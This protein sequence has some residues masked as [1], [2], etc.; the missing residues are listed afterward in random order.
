[1]RPLLATL[2]LLACACGS[3]V[4]EPFDASP[5]EEDAGAQDGDSGVAD[6]PDSG[7]SPGR[8]ASAPRP[9]AATIRPD[10]GPFPVD[11]GKPAGLDASAI[12]PPDA[13]APRPDA[14]A[15]GPDAAAPGPDAGPSCGEYWAASQFTC[16][17]DGNSRVRCFSNELTTEPCP[18]G[19]LRKSSGDDLCL[20][21]S[22]GW[23]CSGSWGTTPSQSGDYFITAFGCWTD[24]IGD[25]HTDPYDNCIPGCLDEARAAGV[26]GAGESG[27]ACE[28]RLNWFVADAGRFGCLA[29]LRITNPATGAS[30]IGIVLDYGP[31]CSIEQA[32]SKPVLDCSSRIDWELFGAEQGNTDRA[33]VHVVEVDPSTPL[34]PV[35]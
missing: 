4:I 19:C 10:S 24:S 17:A 32:V 34:G 25:V 9:D 12:P 20:G 28:E 30:V 18:R 35:P 31:G 29:R 6:L 21:T 23:S 33:L 5:P 22:D 26:C 15:P 3:V 8:D 1:M 13:A 16:T 2:A 27:P 14:A 11:A 7:P